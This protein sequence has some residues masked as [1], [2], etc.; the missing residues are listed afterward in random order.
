MVFV[1]GGF[2]FGAGEQAELLVFEVVG[3]KIMGFAEAGGEVEMGSGAA[4][5]GVDDVASEVMPLALGVSGFFAEFALGALEGIFAGF[6]VA[7]GRGQELIG[8]GVFGLAEEEEVVVVGSGEDVDVV[9][10][11]Q[12]GPIGNFASIGED[13]MVFFDFK[14]GAMIEDESGGAA[15]PGGM[16]RLVHGGS[17]ARRI[18]NGERW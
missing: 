1:E 10:G 9:G 8:D 17:I 16:R 14:E 12:D 2:E 3:V 4:A 11:N 13:D 18:Q 7:A 5:V 6:E 15:R